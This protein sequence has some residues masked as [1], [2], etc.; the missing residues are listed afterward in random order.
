LIRGFDGA[1]FTV[2]WSVVRPAPGECGQLSAQE[3]LEALELSVG[4]V[5]QPA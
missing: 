3:T 4:K 5:D 1:L 2:S